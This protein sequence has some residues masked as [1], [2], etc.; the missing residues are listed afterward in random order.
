MR[1]DTPILTDDKALSYVRD[2]LQAHLP[3]HARGYKCTTETLIDV[4]VA[5]TSQGMSL[6]QACDALPESPHPSAVRGY[7]NEQISV[8]QLAEVENGV[9]AALHGQLPQ[10]L[11]RK[12]LDVAVDVHEQPYYGRTSQE[13]GLWVRGQRKAGTRKSYRIASAY[14]MKRG[15]RFTLGVVFMPYGRTLCDALQALLAQVQRLELHI[16]CLWM[17]RGFASVA[18]MQ[19][20]A[21]HGWSAVVGCPIRGKLEGYGTRALCRGRGSY[22]TQHTFTNR[23]HKQSYTAQLAVCRVFRYKRRHGKRR[24]EGDWEI[25]IAINITLT[26]HQVRARYRHRFGI[27]TGYRCAN[28]V[29]GWTTSHNPAFRFLLLGLALYVYNVWVYLVWHYTQVPRRGGR[30]LDVALLRLSRLKRLLQQALEARYGSVT[31]IT[32]HAAPIP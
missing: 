9:N 3:L 28:Q 17:D 8:E 29:R 31:T 2:E 6:E 24:R 5:M 20:L 22:V 16:Q 25:Y 21:T 32:A 15:L 12:P 27:E 11:W 19:Y 7:L 26:P 23:N 10:Q 13:E 1:K 30:Y 4:L 14:V 18:I